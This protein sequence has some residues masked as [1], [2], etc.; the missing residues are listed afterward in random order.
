MRGGAACAK[1]LLSRIATRQT[2]CAQPAWGRAAHE[3]RVPAG[4]SVNLIG[5]KLRYEQ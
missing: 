5:G 2:I 1:R 3:P 4:M